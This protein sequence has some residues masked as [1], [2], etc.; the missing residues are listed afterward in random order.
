MVKR[1]KLYIVLGIIMFS[2]S[3]SVLIHELFNNVRNGRVIR[4]WFTNSFRH[5]LLDLIVGFLNLLNKILIFILSWQ[6]VLLL[7]VILAYISFKQYMKAKFE[8]E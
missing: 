4:G 3:Q 7:A 1:K 8:K 6:G 5:I 2:L